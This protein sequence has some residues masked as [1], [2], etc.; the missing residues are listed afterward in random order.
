MPSYLARR[1]PMLGF[2]S[3]HVANGWQSRTISQSIAQHARS[4]PLDGATD[5]KASGF[6]LS[7]PYAKIRC[8]VRM[9]SWGR[10]NSLPVR[11]IRETRVTRTDQ[12]FL[13]DVPVRRIPES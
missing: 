5:R 10:R 12:D 9:P 8:P 3:V 2:G 4:V 6:D 13:Y 7:K 11:A 1:E